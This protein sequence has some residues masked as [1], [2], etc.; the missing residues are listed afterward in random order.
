LVLLFSVFLGDVLLY[1]F[2]CFLGSFLV[3]VVVFGF[4]FGF[5]L[6]FWVPFPAFALFL[7]GF[8]MFWLPCQG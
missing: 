3:F 2:F 4:F 6:R 5:Y 1:P 7:V 8:S